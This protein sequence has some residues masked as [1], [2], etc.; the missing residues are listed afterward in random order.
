MLLTTQQKQHITTLLR[1]EI[2]PLTVGFVPNAHEKFFRLREESLYS[3]I[4]P[5]FSSTYRYTHKYFTH[6]QTKA[7]A[8]RARYSSKLR[9]RKGLL[10]KK[11]E[12]IYV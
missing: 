3:I 12:T 1:T 7:H 5:F 8:C 10:Y 11:T 4:N 6:T 9:K 2:F